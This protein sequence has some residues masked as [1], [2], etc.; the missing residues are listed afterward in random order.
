[1]ATTQR[2]R[3][4][5]FYQVVALRDGV[6]APFER[7]CPWSDVLKILGDVPFEQRVVTADRDLIGGAQR[8]LEKDHLLLHKVKSDQ[9]WLSHADFR[10]GKIQTLESK[11]GEGYLDTSVVCFAGYGN[12]I[13]IMEG[14]T[15]APSHRTLELWLNKMG[16]LDE[17]IAIQPVLSPAEFDKLSQAEA[18]QRVEIKTSTR[19]DLR[20]K[21]GGLASA[22]RTLR[23][24]Y[25]DASV[26]ITVSAGRGKK[27]GGPDDTRRRLYADL[28]EIGENLRPA[29]R[30]RVGLLFRDGDNY[31]KARVTEL[32]EHHVTAKRRVTAVDEEGNAIRILGA[33][34]AILSALDEYEVEL[35]A[36]VGLE[37]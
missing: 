37:E 10:T 2:E 20:G 27:V 11:A 28:E 7:E 8:Y 29:D 12:I 1:M 26:T 3:T 36:C 17:Q 33:I 6:T 35:R 18:I 16:L 30:A 23:R 14:S 22:L 9:D 32:V 31:S 24:D 15:S 21:T 25:G 19:I 5:A 13:A 34:S 4:V